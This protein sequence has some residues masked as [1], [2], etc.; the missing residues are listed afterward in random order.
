[1]PLAKHP[2]VQFQDPRAALV[3]IFSGTSVQFP[4]VAAPACTP[5]GTRRFWS[6]DASRPEGS[7]VALRCGLVC[8]S[9]R[10]RDAERLFMDP[11]TLCIS[12]KNE[13]CAFLTEFQG[14]NLHPG[15]SLNMHFSHVFQPC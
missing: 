13:N 7:E 9:L 5:A 8:V 3:F 4:T 2:E 6:F 10:P 11:L 14:S 12:K 15:S 1:M